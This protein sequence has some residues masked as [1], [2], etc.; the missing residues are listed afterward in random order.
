[1]LVR[2]RREPELRRFRC[3]FPVH[4][5]AKVAIEFPVVLALH[6]TPLRRSKI[7]YDEEAQHGKETNV[8]LVSRLINGIIIKTG[9]EFSYHCAVGAPTRKRQIG[10]RSRRRRLRR[11]K[12]ALLDCAAIGNA[13]Y[14]AAQARIRSFS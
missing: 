12:L 1:M 9:D 7:T 4:K 13:N 8:R 3:R 11:F 2:L 10:A 5:A 14:G 6:E